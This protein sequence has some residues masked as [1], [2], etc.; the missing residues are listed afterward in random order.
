MV[1]VTAEA[2]AFSSGEVTIKRGDV[3]IAQG[4]GR[5]PSGTK[6][7]PIKISGHIDGRVAPVS[8]KGGVYLSGPA[9][10][11]EFT[12]RAAVGK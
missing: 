8:A 2:Y 1:L 10:R 7:Y 4:G 12:L 6:L 11:A 5:I 9:F 3:L